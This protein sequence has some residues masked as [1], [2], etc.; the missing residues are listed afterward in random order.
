MLRLDQVTG[1]LV[2][3][4]GKMG[5]DAIA[6]FLESGLNVFAFDE[7]AVTRD[8]LRGNVLKT[9]QWIEKKRKDPDKN[10]IHPEGFAD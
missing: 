9:L 10:P 3:G 8:G 1:V 7:A 5:G 6:Q 4:A 2:V